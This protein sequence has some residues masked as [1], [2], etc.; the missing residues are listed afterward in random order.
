MKEDTLQEE[1]TSVENAMEIL[2]DPL[3]DQL[4]REKAIRYLSYRPFDRV[5]KKLV[6]ALQYDE[7]AIRWEAAIALAQLGEKALPE[8][9][10]ALIDPKKVGDPRLRE[11]VYHVLH[12]NRSPFY[13]V[14]I[15]R[16]LQALKGPAADISSME[17]ASRLL[18]PIE[19]RRPE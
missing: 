10:R 15:T 3:E 7:F 9:L 4:L 17:E 19:T 1:I 5:I 18:R 11:G 14:N 16:L 13:S 2:D 12:Y 8:L 6:E